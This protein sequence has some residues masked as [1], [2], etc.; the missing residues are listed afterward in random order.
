MSEI[1]RLY[2]SVPFNR[3]PEEDANLIES[4]SLSVTYPANT[5]IFAQKDTPS[6]YLYYIQKGSVEI[7]S[8]TSEAVEMVV[9]TRPAGCFFGWT[10]VFTN[11]NYTAGAKTT[12]ESV[13]LLIPKEELLRLANQYPVISNHF[14]KAVYSQIRKLY[15]D[16]VERNSMDPVAQMEAY[17]FQKKLKEIMSK[18]VETCSVNTTVRDIAVKMTEAGIA[19]VVITDDNGKIAGI[20]TE[21]DL[22]RKVL[23]RDTVDCLKHSTAHD[24]MTLDPYYMTPDTFMYEAV[25]FMLRHGI[26]HLPILD[27]D[28]IEGIVSLQDLMKFRSQKSML[29]V[30]SAKEAVTVDELKTVRAE[31]V[32]VAKMLLSENRSHTET[33]EILSYVHHSIIRR[34]YEIILKEMLQSGYEMPDVRHCFIIMGSGGRKEMLLGPDQDNG[35]LYGDFPDE[36]SE[37]VDAF[38]VP[39]SERLVE[40]L[41]HIGYPLCHGKVMANNPLWRGRLSEWKE[42]V[43]SWIK[44]PEPQRVRYSSIFFDFM[45]IGGD[46]SLCVSL[47]DMVHQ[48]IKANPLFLFQMMELD[49]K[50]K[51]PINLL[52]RFITSSEKEHKGRLSLKENGSIFIVDCVRMF[53][54][55]HGIHAVT[56]VERLDRLLELNIFNRATVEHI[57]AAFESFTYLRLKNEIK[58]IEAGNEPSH[59]LDP[60]ELTEEEADLLKEAFKVAGK[61]QDSTRRHFSKIIGR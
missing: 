37:S 9:D 14:S 39:F 10:P 27:G 29:L 43:S 17:P 23:A 4:I 57:K 21:R 41:D 24:I 2:S 16:M 26:R 58:M 52:G 50:H 7:I 31:V 33:M 61:L 34:C 13:C 32:K 59:Y 47:R 44:V 35:L 18:P 45:P 12:E 56:T 51:I 11:E 22:V 6:G 15:Q 49:Y 53:M 5:V 38:F 19:A 40:A 42:R 54:L 48:Q 28:S 8:E 60:D 36:M 46:G 3:I 1:T 25:T 55:E 30:G 20:V